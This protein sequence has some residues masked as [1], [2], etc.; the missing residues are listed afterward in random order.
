MPTKVTAGSVAGATERVTFSVLPDLKN[1]T[2]RKNILAQADRAAR[3][4]RTQ[5]LRALKRRRST[6]S[7]TTA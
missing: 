3:H 5:R 6:R 4:S 7:R 1:V 2:V